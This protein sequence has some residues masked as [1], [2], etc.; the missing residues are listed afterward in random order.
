MTGNYA[1][2]RHAIILLYEELDL[3]HLGRMHRAGLVYLVGAALQL[4]ED[5]VHVVVNEYFGARDDA[6]PDHLPPEK[7][8]LTD[9]EGYSDPTP[10][11]AAELAKKLREDYDI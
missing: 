5:E 4:S 1:E 11:E 10:A 9:D 6:E 3:L 8:E 2:E 7:D